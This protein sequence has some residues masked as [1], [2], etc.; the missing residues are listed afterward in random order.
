[1]ADDI[2]PPGGDVIKRQRQRRRD[3][4]EN[5]GVF[6]PGSF[7]T[8]GDLP[9]ADI[10]KPTEKQQGVPVG[11]GD[12]EAVCK[13][14]ETS[15]SEGIQF[16]V[17]EMIKQFNESHEEALED[18]DKAK[19][20]SQIGEYEI[21]EGEYV[22][23]IQSTRHVA[24][25]KYQSASIYQFN[26]DSTDSN[27]DIFTEKCHQKHRSGYQNVNVSRAQ[28]VPAEEDSKEIKISAKYE[29]SVADSDGTFRRSR[30]HSAPAVTFPDA[31]EVEM[32]ESD[33]SSDSGSSYVTDSD[34]A[35]SDF[36]DS[37]I[38][39]EVDLNENRNFCLFFILKLFI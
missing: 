4:Y 5:V 26:D 30:L 3:D 14:E 29:K 35:E 25:Q 8:E 19:E 6:N 23:I 27:S 33:T 12:D 24:D 1:M 15:E 16:S 31:V 13:Q 36:E 20:K 17:S 9:N 11:H 37:D 21:K 10:N 2:T 38:K 18:P 28:S 34:F 22:H 7:K 32:E 39:S